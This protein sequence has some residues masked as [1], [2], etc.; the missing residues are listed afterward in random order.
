MTNLTY[1]HRTLTI[2]MKQ[3]NIKHSKCLVKT[4]PMVTSKFP[5]PLFFPVKNQLE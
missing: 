4:K 2:Q 3:F 5:C 1:V